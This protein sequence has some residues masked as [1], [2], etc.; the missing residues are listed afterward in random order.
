MN[1]VQPGWNAGCAERCLS[2]VGER[3]AEFHCREAAWTPSF[4]SH[5]CDYSAWPIIILMK[6]D[7]P[8]LLE[9]G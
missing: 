4:D 8:A 2:G 6:T 9:K 3:W 1:L 5:F 7:L